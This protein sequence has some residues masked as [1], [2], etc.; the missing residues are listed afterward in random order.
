VVVVV[1]DNRPQ[2]DDEDASQVFVAEA[3]EVVAVVVVQEVARRT[4]QQIQVQ[5]LPPEQLSLVVLGKV[6]QSIVSVSR[7]VVLVD[8]QA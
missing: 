1:E 3:V 2:Q 5:N 7:P 8:V 6:Q 4:I